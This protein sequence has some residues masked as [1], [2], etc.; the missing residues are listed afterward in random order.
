MVANAVRWTV[1]DLE[2]MPDDSGWKRYE[3]ID[4][5]LFTTLA[6]SIWHQSAAGQLL[7]ALANWSKN[8]GS[9]RTLMSPG[10]VF[11]PEDAVIPDLVWVADQ[12]L[13]NRINEN[14]HFTVT[15]EL[16][17]EVLSKGE[18]YENWDRVTKRKFYSIHGV[19]EYWIVDWR[20]KT[21]EVYRRNQA[22]LELVCTLL[23]DDILTSPLLPEFEV[24][25]AKVFS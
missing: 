25:I 14:G 18:N 24:A 22:Q 8:S 9:G 11:S 13:K 15:P 23:E 4:G 17:V 6:P 3:V 19:R 16:V 10:V 7:V 5:E 12:H 20:Q 21:I 1:Q 2:V